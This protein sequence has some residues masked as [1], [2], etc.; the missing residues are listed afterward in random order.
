MKKKDNKC[1]YVYCDEECK[2]CS[3]EQCPHYRKDYQRNTEK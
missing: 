3:C 2:C 1:I